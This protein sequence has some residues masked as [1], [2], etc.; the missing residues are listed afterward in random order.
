MSKVEEHS[1]T[2][3]LA[4]TALAAL[5]VVYG[6]IGTSP[7]YAFRECFAGEGGFEVSQENVL[8]VLSLIFWALILIVSIKY[9]AY[10][11][12][13]DNNGEGGVLALMTLV[14]SA[15]PGKSSKRPALIVIGLFGAC[16]LYGDGMITPAISVLAAIEGLEVATPALSQYVVPIAIVILCILFALQRTGTGAIGKVFGPI[17]LLW[18]FCLAA[19][20][21]PW[22]LRT[23][24]VLAA[25]TPLPAIQFF[26]RHGQGAA[27][28]LGGVFLVVTGGEALYADMG[29]FGR[30]PIRVAWFGLVLPALMIHYFGQGALLIEHPEFVSNPFYLMAPEWALYPLVALSTF[31]TVIASQAVISGAFSLTRQAVQLGFLPRVDIRQTSETH[32]GQIYV[33]FVNWVLLL[34][35]VGLVLGFGSSQNL[36]GAYGVA[37]VSTMVI[38]TILGFLC[39]RMIWKWKLVTAASL[40]LAFLVIDLAFLSANIIKIPDGGWFPLLVAAIAFFIMATWRKGHRNLRRRLQERRVEFPQFLEDMEKLKITRVPGTAVF[41]DGIPEGIP[42]TLLHNLKHNQV[43]HETVVILTIITQEIPVVP[44]D[45]RMEVA[46][47]GHGFFRILAYYGFLETPKI[48]AILREARE[49][50]VQYEG[51]HQTTFFLGRETLIEGRRHAMAWWRESLFIFMT[52]NQKSADQYFGI[53]AG[54]VVELG[55]QVPV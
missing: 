54:R 5:G 47:L 46:D 26:L 35:T 34:A 22:I 55:V 52:R 20:G 30:K 11:M 17:T 28:V 31:A 7:L 42:H 25:I 29:H 18:F 19:M 44:H 16:L 40:S 32:I 23:P 4:V 43:V 14:L 12:R 10:I 15:V 51:V 38:T 39:S 24:S 49:E 48:T 41:L 50:G 6:D 27:F 37:V 21:I 3:R 9:L 33:P 2:S 45:E 36:A 13:A 53:P 1:K 8:G